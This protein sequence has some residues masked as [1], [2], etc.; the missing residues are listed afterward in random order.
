MT[1][2]GEAK[3]K[4]PSIRDDLKEDDASK[5]VEASKIA[6]KCLKKILLP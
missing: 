1:G 5:E 2:V 3:V 6:K 4:S